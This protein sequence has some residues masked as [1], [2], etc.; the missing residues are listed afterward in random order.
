MTRLETVIAVKDD[1]SSSKWYQDLLDLQSTHGGDNFE[2]LADK[3]GLQSYLFT[4]GKHTSA[5][6]WETLTSAL[7]MD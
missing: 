5:Q 1:A 6:Q 4:D 7:V 2:K 3:T